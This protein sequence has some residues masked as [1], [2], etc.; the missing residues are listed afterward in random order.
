[1]QTNKPGPINLRKWENLNFTPP[2]QD[3][4]RDD[5]IDILAMV[6]LFFAQGVVELSRIFSILRL[7]QK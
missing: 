1:M 5:F 4:D 6:V 2:V 3:L 7:V